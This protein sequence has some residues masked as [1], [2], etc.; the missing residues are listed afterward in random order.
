MFRFVMSQ[1]TLGSKLHQNLRI[2]LFAIYYLAA[3]GLI[4]GLI[5]YSYDNG[6]TIGQGY[7]DFVACSLRTRNDDRCYNTHRL[8]YSFLLISQIL[9]A[10]GENDERLDLKRA[11]THLYRRWFG[12]VRGIRYRPY[13]DLVLVEGAVSTPQTAGP[14]ER[15][16]PHYHRFSNQYEVCYC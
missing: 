4:I 16:T 6:D 3:V 8:P 15:G 2:L 10:I 5:W 11:L 7:S 14:K 13:N 12:A 1:P 9:V